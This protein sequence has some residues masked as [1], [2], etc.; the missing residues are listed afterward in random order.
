MSQ[1][2]SG[3][4]YE[5]LMPF[6][7]GINSLNGQWFQLRSPTK[8]KISILKRDGPGSLIYIFTS[9]PNLWSWGYWTIRLYISRAFQRY[10][11]LWNPT[12]GSKVMALW[13]GHARPIGPAHYS[14]PRARYSEMACCLVPRTSSKA[15]FLKEF[16]FPIISTL[17]S[18]YKVFLRS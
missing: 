4:D 14:E 5:E 12:Y 18:S 8:C 9:S 2:S 3:F 10:V 13:S 1:S 11:K 6:W 17:P 16:P 7:S 15:L